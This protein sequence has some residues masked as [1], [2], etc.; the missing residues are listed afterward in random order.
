MINPEYASEVERAWSIISLL[1]LL[2]HGYL[3]VQAFLDWRAVCT[4]TLQE[5]WRCHSALGYF[6]GQ[7]LLFVPHTLHLYIGVG[8][9][10][11][12]PP[13]TE[14]REQAAQTFQVMLI[15]AQL[16]FAA[17]AVAFWLARRLLA[18]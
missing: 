18:R 15:T 13:V 11:L 5:P 3:S 16:M 7:F 17:A 9:M 14:V 8:S 6:I 4:E 10:L 1:G 2:L 12:P